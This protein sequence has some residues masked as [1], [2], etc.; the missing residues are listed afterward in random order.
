[1][2]WKCTEGIKS[3]V[4]AFKFSTR[5]ITNS[6]IRRSAERNGISSCSSGRLPESTFSL[7]LS[8][9]FSFS[10]IYVHFCMCYKMVCLVYARYAII[11]MGFQRINT[12]IHERT[13]L[14]SIESS[15]T[16]PLCRS[17]NNHAVFVLI[18]KKTAQ[19]VMLNSHLVRSIAKWS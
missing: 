3:S 10:T 4:N 7:A 8:L 15:I 1:M 14:V 5:F 17:T 6:V 11:T 16:I 13:C 2:A 12:H 18:K 9:S 19:R